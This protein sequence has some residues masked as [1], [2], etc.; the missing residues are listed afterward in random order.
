MA[1]RSLFSSHLGAKLA[2]GLI[3]TFAAGLASAATL[4]A[5]YLFNNGLTSSLSGAPS[6]VAV[7]PNG[8]NTFLTD[9]V[10]GLSRTVYATNSGATHQTQAGL[11]LDATGLVSTTDYSMEMVFEVTGGNPSYKRLY[12][13]GAND[14]GLYVD[15]ANKL[16]I[17]DS[18]TGGS[19]GELDFSLNTYH[20]LVATVSGGFASV[21]LDGISGT[22]LSTTALNITAPGDVLAFYIDD[23]AEYTSARTALIRMWDGA[24]SASDVSALS[25]NPLAPRADAIPE[26]AGM[27]LF[28]TALGFMG[29]ATLRRRRL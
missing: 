21:W 25:A 23:V 1:I 8:T 16:N 5:E 3:T 22:P 7:N 27:A 13:T 19:H 2:L 15:A 11:T 6:L 4:K 14:N 17:Y 20:H 26:P 10:F 24:L 9:T 12:Q 29:L 28:T 18:S